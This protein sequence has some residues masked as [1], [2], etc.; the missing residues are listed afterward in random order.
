V[1]TYDLFV[2]LSTSTEFDYY[3]T[4]VVNFEV[5]T[6]DQLRFEI[7]QENADPISTITYGVSFLGSPQNL[8]FDLP[9]PS[10]TPTNTITPSITPTNTQTPTNTPTNSVTPTITPTPTTTQTS[11]NTPTNTQTPSQT[12]TPLPVPIVVGGEFNQLNETTRYYLVR[13]NNDGTEDASFY[14][15]L[16]TGFNNVVLT[17]TIQSDGKILVGGIFTTL[18]GITRNRLVRLNND[19]TEDTSF[20][21][22]LGTGFDNLVSTILIQSDGK[23]LV[24]GNF[25]NLNEITRRD[26][27]RL[28]SDGTVDESFYTNLGTGFGGWVRS[29]QIQSDGKILVGGLFTTL[30][31]I[32]RN[33]LVRLN[34]DGTED[35]FFYTNLGTGFNSQVRAISIQ[36]D[37]KILIGGEFNQ[38]NETTRYYLVR[39]N[40]DGTID[41]SFYTNLGTGFNNVVL[42][43]SIQSDG[44]IL[45]GGYFTNLNGN[46]RNRLVRLNNDGTEDTS[47]YTNLGTGFGPSVRDL[48]NIILIQSDEKILVGGSFTTLNEIT[49]NNLVRL[50]NDGTVDTSFYTNLGTGFNFGVMTITSI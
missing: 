39:L 49:R 21:T 44:K 18:D 11:T 27:V 38:L 20:Y 12:S 15:N 50:N 17:T 30:D 16:G 48:V 22:N 25:V 3:G 37:G 41:E 7:T 10:I 4:N 13:L 5:N 47:F 40:N 43:I 8:T 35:A 46:T 34:N 45:V 36:S 29:I 2:R 31:G 14:T 33:R 6:G 23:I 9:T 26:L 28:N 42:S 19:G 1:S 24:G 32:T